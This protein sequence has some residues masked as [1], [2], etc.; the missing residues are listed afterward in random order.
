MGQKKIAQY[1]VEKE[2]EHHCFDEIKYLLIQNN[3]RLSDTVVI[4]I[5]HACIIEDDTLCHCAQRFLNVC[6]RGKFSH[7]K[8][9]Q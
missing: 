6:A 2:F 1:D 7:T 3:T 4:Y 8:R 9:I 5:V